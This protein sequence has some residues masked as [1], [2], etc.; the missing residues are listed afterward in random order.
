MS[1]LQSNWCIPLFFASPPAAA[2]AAAAPPSHAARRVP[3]PP[4]RTTRVRTKPPHRKTHAPVATMA[5]LFVR[6]LTLAA[7]SVASS[8]A[9]YCGG[10]PDPNA[11]PNAYPIEKGAPVFSHSVANGHAF[12]AGPP[13]AEFRVMHLYG[14]AYVRARRGA[15]GPRGGARAAAPPA[16]SLPP[17]CSH[18]CFRARLARLARRKWALRTVRCTPPTP[19]RC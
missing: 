10:A 18:R 6:A 3:R 1:T 14:S 4:L 11:Q 2:G 9:A 12:V 19:A 15:R 17:S 16:A 8:H 13:G 7:L 5:P